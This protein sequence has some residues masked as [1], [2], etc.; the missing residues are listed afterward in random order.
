MPR[1]FILFGF[2]AVHSISFAGVQLLPLLPVAGTTNAVQLDA[3]GNIYL[4]GTLTPANVVDTA[5][6]FV[7]KL[8]PDG[9]KLLYLTPIAGSQADV[10]T[11][12]AVG[13]DG[14]TYVTGYTSS[15]DFPV[16]AGALQSTYQGSPQYQGFLVKVDPSGATANATYINGTSFTQITGIALDRTGAILL[17]GTGGPGYDLSRPQPFPGFVLKLD[18]AM[19]RVVSVITGYGGGL[20][21][22]DGQGNIY[23]AGRAQAGTPP[24]GG[25]V[26]TLPT[27]SANA[28]QPTHDARFCVEAGG[29]PSPGFSSSCSYQYVAK[30]DPTGALLWGTYVTG[31]YGAFPRGMAIDSAGNVVVAGTTN[32]DDYPVTSGAFQTAY[33]AAAPPFPTL[34]GGAFFRDSPPST[35]YVT[36]VNANGTALIWSTYFGGSFSD[37]ITGLAVG[38]NGDIYISGHAA[39]NDLP[40][41][42][43]TP[44]GCRPSASQQLGFVARLSSDGAEAGATHL[45]TGAPDCIYLGCPIGFGSS[46]IKGSWPLVLRPSG[47]LFTAGTNGTVASVD[48]SSSSRLVCMTDPADGVQLR[49]VAP[50]QVVTLFGNDLAPATPFIPRDLV[51][52]STSNF[53]VTFNGILA[54]ILYSSAEQINV[55][56]PFEIAGQSTVQMQVTDNQIPLVLK[57][58]RTLAVADRQP[59]MFIAP[60]AIAG[61]FPGYTQCGSAISI[62]APAVAINA[63]GTL[64]DCTHSA[65]AG[66]TVTLLV[67][68]LG[69]VS[70]ALATGVK[71]TAPAATLTPGVDA[72]LSNAVPIPMVTATIPGVLS[73]VNAVQ[74]QV[75]PVVGPLSPVT[76]APK[77]LGKPLRVRLVVIWARPN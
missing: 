32:S 49:S 59:A 36:K 76:I 41:L 30:L 13:A 22:L 53:G 69:Q 46:S 39:S 11:A 27:L 45:V 21:Q 42:V 40:A 67:D 57:E 6:G 16:T 18:A 55:Q 71:A 74:F 48:F 23:L 26:P 15:R 65:V 4:T 61:A 17:T 64:N 52:P 5:D 56:V 37:Q 77:V 43:A 50:G 47:G 28:F 8:S 60:E 19:S 25:I 20:I 38:P 12:L 33:T 73:G 63:D 72:L 7:A 54:P 3:T 14:S 29:G 31:T 2:L 66:S 35:G 51:A 24:S 1:A 10:P 75:P 34:P 62:G 58:T 68:G 9:T 44:D 70:P